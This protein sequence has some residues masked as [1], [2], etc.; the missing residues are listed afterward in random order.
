MAPGR[1]QASGP[2]IFCLPGGKPD[3][4][5]KPLEALSRELDE[6]LGVRRLSGRACRPTSRP[7]R[8]WKGCR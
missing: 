4:G 3:P 1:E 2:K 5:E 6:E 7:S 8:P